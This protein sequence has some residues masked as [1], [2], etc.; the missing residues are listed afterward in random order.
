MRWPD[1]W[2]DPAALARIAEEISDDD[3]V[4]GTRDHISHSD[5]LLK[6]VRC[7]VAEGNLEGVPTGRYDQSEECIGRILNSTTRTRGVARRG[8]VAILALGP[9]IACLAAAGHPGSAPHLAPVPAATTVSRAPVETSASTPASRPAPILALVQSATPQ[10]ARNP[11][12]KPESR[13]AQDG[14]AAVALPRFEVASVKPTD[15]SRDVRV[16]VQVRPGG[17]VAIYGCELKA[18]MIIAFGISSWQLS[19]GDDW[20]DEVKYDVE[21]KPPEAMQAAINDLRYTLFEIEDE[22]LRQMLQALLIDRFQLKFHRQTR[23]GDVYLLE[24]NGKPLALDPTDA[25]PSSLR[26]SGGG[27]GYVTGQWNMRALSMPQLAKYAADYV[28]HVPVLDRTELSGHFKYKQRVPDVD[29]NYDGDSRKDSFLNFIQ[30][31]GLKFQ[32]AK[33]PVETFVID[34]AAKASPN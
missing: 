13:A 15:L 33:G 18:L 20:T 23:T 16:G 9:P 17:R 12:P 27:I 7:G 31:L 29:P 3:A 28:L 5:I 1:T 26:G 4:A 30:E 11:E 22:H 10:S 21:A 32:R 24:R 8:L 6:H 2:K 25:D 34:H 19:G 14:A